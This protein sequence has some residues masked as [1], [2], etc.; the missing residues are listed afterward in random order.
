MP[1]EYSFYQF[2]SIDSE[3]KMNIRMATDHNHEK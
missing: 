1:H 2:S 3:L